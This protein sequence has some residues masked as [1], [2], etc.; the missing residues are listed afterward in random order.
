[1]AKCEILDQFQ[2]KIPLLRLFR[3]A[4][5]AEFKP[6]LEMW[7][8]NFDSYPEI[9]TAFIPLLMLL[10]WTKMA[11]CEILDQFQLKIPLL[12]LFGKNEPKCKIL[13]RSQL[14]ISPLRFFVDVHYL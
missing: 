9:Y 11:K 5:G 10:K 7:G 2:L 3:G 1:M 6:T 13:D 8:Q 14:K 12:R 4:S